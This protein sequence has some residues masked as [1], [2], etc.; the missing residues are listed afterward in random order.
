MMAPMILGILILCNV[1]M[2]FVSSLA[3]KPHNYVII[4]NTFPANKIADPQ[5]L[6]FSKSYRKRQFQLA[7]ILSFLD[8]LLLIPMKDSSFMLLF[9][10]L[11]YLAIGANY[12][13]MLRYIRKGHQLI[14]DNQWQLPIQPVQI[15]T[16]LVLN[17]NRKLVSPW[18]FLLT[19]GLNLLFSFLLYRQ[20]LG[21]LTWVLL[22]TNLAVWLTLLVTWWV[23][24]RLPVRAL[25]DDRK[26]NQQYNDLTK[27][28]WS[29]LTVFLSGM[30]GVLIYVP[31]LTTTLRPN[32]FT[33]LMV[34]EFVLIFFFCGSTI[35][36]LFRLRQKQDQLLTESTT[37][38][39]AGDDYY[40]RYG[41]YCN[42]DDRRLMI[43]DRIGMN[44]SINLGKVG[45]KIFIGLLPVILVVATLVTVVPLYILDYHPNPLT[46]ELKNE[47]VLL[48]GPFVKEQKI[49]LSKIEDVRLVNHLPARSVRTNGLAT[50]NYAIGYF[51]MAGKSSVLLIDHTSKPILKLVTKKRDY[52]YTN[53]K[54]TETKKLYQKIQAEK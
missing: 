46:Y 6:H 33:F 15:D 37:M 13:I 54:P 30:L 25:T 47:T 7:L 17:K 28:Y 1:I 11:L 3:A 27:F 16:K 22:L 26:L 45:G 35:W 9:F 2:A 20:Q 38:R 34:V 29:S 50:N 32:Y 10:L 53:T 49:P 24:R 36:W 8:L 42:P 44:I 40:W 5:V 51:Q 21:S 4:E 52:F 48:D 31:L 12:F 19:L 43:P 23:I 39:Y 18:W 14:I 41:I